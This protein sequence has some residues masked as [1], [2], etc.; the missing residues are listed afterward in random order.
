M[1]GKNGT[2]LISDNDPGN[3]NNQGPAARGG[4]QTIWSMD[5]RCP[6]CNRMVSSDFNFCIYCRTDLRGLK[7][8]SPQPAPTSPTSPFATPEPQMQGMGQNMGAQVVPDDDDH[9]TARNKLMR[10]THDEAMNGC[11]KTLEIDGQMI[12]VD[13]PA[14]IVD[15]EKLDVP[16]YGY[17]DNQTGQRGPLRLSIRVV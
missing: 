3:V 9:P 4:T 16:G 10:L 17:F 15:R 7:K 1:A 11:R 8:G 2:V 6:N 5:I 13:I 12:Q 14:G